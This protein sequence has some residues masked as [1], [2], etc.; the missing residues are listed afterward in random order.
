MGIYFR[1]VNLMLV[2][3]KCAS[4]RKAVMI[5]WMEYL[6]VHLSQQVENVM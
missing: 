5:K 2:R 1:N 4:K 6:E 3:Y